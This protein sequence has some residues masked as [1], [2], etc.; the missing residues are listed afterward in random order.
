M[1]NLRKNVQS[2]WDINVCDYLKGVTFDERDSQRFMSY[3]Y[4]LHELEIEKDEGK[5]VLE[6]GVGCG[7]D[8]CASIRLAKPALYVL[9]DISTRTIEVAKEHLKIHCKLDDAYELVVGD[10]TVLMFKDGEFDR[11]KAIGSLHHIPNITDA[12][13]EI[14]RVLKVNGDFIFM[15]Y[16]KDSFR[17][18]FTYRRVA[19][20]RGRDIDDLVFEVD[21]KGNPFSRVYSKNEIIQMCS[22]VGLRCIKFRTY[23]MLNDE[24]RLLRI[25]APFIERFF[26]W[27]IYI[28]GIKVS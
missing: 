15:L 6:I 28:H 21:G 10:A 3:P 24:R 16:N 12:I 22:L 1:G 2:F 27:A 4:L 23:E 5:R 18:R 20:R 25:L 11:V 9:L 7:S 13:H 14:S 19:R 8:G 17:Y 26:G